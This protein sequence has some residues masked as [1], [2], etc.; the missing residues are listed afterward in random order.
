M[1][2]QMNDLLTSLESATEDD[3]TYVL[4][5]AAAEAESRG[6]ISKEIAMSCREFICCGAFI[7]A[8]ITLVPEG[9][10]WMID[11]ERIKGGKPY[12]WVH[13][14]INRGRGKTRDGYGST[15]AVALCIAAIRAR[16]KP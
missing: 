8:A 16:E 6:W 7:D 4:L 5:R 11:S 9:W 14:R 2:S 1:S 12:A 15:P 13:R 10:H 3:Q